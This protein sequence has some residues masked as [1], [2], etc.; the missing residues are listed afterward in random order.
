[1]LHRALEV[2]LELLDLR[3]VRERKV[4]RG[5]KVPKATVVSSACKVFQVLR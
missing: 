4:K 1:L 2:S 3:V 5:L